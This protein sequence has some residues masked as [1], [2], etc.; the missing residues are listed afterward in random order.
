[1][2]HF[3]KWALSSSIVSGMDAHAI[4]AFMLQKFMPE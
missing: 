3:D 2:A 1:M 4:V